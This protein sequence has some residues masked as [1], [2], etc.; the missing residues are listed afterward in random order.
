MPNDLPFRLKDYLE[1]VDWMG[2]AILEHKRGYIQGDQP[3][4]LDR[5]QINPQHWLYMTQHFE[6]RFKGIVGASYKL[7]EACQRLGYQRTPN[8]GIALQY[9][10]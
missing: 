7:K 9:F 2:H 8:L 6:S 3:P 10:S 5:L 1:L 4:I